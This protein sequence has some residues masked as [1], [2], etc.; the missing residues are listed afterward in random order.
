M[1]EDSFVSDSSLGG[2]SKHLVTKTS[3]T[4]AR[5]VQGLDLPGSSSQRNE[6]KAE[7][8]SGGVSMPKGFVDCISGTEKSGSLDVRLP[9]ASATLPISLYLALS[10][11]FRCFAF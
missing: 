9:T 3:V 1:G 6:T 7:L 5:V 11:Q 4:V 10:L 2:S 8:W